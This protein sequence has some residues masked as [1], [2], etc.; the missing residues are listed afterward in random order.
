MKI[1]LHLPSKATVNPET[2]F[3]EVNTENLFSTPAMP[4][5][6]PPPCAEMLIVDKVGV[7][8]VST[9]GVHTKSKNNWLVE[10]VR[11]S[12]VKI[13]NE[14]ESESRTPNALT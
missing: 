9:K 4:L 13:G 5:I 2:G 8:V 11:T 3:P 6:R 10:L 12:K 1:T 7:L 14:A